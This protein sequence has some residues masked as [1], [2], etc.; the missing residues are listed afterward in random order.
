MTHL[1]DQEYE[2]KRDRLV[3]LI[4]G[5]AHPYAGAYLDE[6]ETDALALVEALVPRS[7]PGFWSRLWWG[8]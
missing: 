3:A 4:K 8:S 5:L 6:W 1:T 7:R 2:T